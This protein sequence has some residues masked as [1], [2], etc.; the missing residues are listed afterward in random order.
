MSVIFNNDEKST[1]VNLVRLFCVIR[2]VLHALTKNLHEW[3]KR[4]R[5][6]KVYSL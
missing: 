2:V 4:K 6:S 1:D 3:R 5:V